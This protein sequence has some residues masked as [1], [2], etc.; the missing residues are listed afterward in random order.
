MPYYFFILVTL[1]LLIQVT[2][3]INCCFKQQ[4]NE[5]GK[6]LHV[7]SDLGIVSFFPDGAIGY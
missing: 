2:V 5:K 4:L 6:T 7:L 3:P 1:K